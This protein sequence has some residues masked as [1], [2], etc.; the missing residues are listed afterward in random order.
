MN[1]IVI[2]NVIYSLQKIGGISSVFYEITNRLLKE[3]SLDVEFVEY[4]DAKENFY[5]KM[6]SIESCHILNKRNKRLLF[7][8]YSNP[9]LNI[10][11]PYIYHSSYYRVS[12]DKSA[13][14]VTTVHD[15]TYEYYGKGLKKKVH[16]W[17]KYNAIRHSDAIVCISEN[18]KRDLL[19]F[20]PDVDENKLH[21][22]YNGVSE[23]Y[24]IINKCE[25]CNLPYAP[26]TYLVFVGSRVSYKNFEL[27]VR[28]VAHSNYNF[29][30]VGSKLTKK[31]KEYVSRYL[32]QERYKA[33]GFLT[34]QELN[35][36][37]NNAAALVY[38]SS[39][40]GF[41]I[42]VL[43]AQRAGCPVIAYNGSSIPEIIGDTPL[44]MK[45]LSEKELLSKLNMISNTGLI[46]QIR[47]LGLENSKRFSWD[48][49]Y[50]EYE[51]L[52]NS[53]ISSLKG[54]PGGGGGD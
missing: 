31:E 43:E 7:D 1:K 4:T 29:V 34:N 20:H 51:A 53:L 21:V 16:C 48:K 8:R 17:Q 22:I 9:Q 25:D 45:E 42:P 41:G 49:A 18:T 13:I 37:Y 2:D 24:C 36:L 10:V 26:N 6:L 38:P 30:I 40:E 39:Y 3:K 19:K 28:G 11:E 32:S 23:N 12:N 50:K 54:R 46:N 44:L 27:A 15:F 47:I 52:Y 35:V 33:V 5:R 14:N